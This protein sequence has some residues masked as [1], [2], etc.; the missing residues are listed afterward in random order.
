MTQK[1]IKRIG[2]CVVGETLLLAK[3]KSSK[4]FSKDSHFV[5]FYF[6]WI[7]TKI[8]YAHL[9]GLQAN[10]AMTN[11]LRRHC[12]ANCRFAKAIQIKPKGNPN[13]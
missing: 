7:A 2:V 1:R 13:A 4:N 12:E 10:L 3:A 8:R 5:R 11:P 9:Q 6:I